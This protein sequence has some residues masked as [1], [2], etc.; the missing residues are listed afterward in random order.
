MRKLIMQAFAA[1]LVAGTLTG[2]AAA[3]G[4]SA[5]TPPEPVTTA[6]LVQNGPTQQRWL[7]V[8]DSRIVLNPFNVDQGGSEV[9]QNS[10]PELPLNTGYY[11]ADTAPTV[12][13][14][15]QVYRKSPH[16]DDHPSAVGFSD[17]FDNL[18]PAWAADGVS[19]TAASGQATL[20]VTNSR[21]Y[22]SISR[23]VSV[24]LSA[25]PKVTITVP[26]GTA[27]WA[28]KVNDGASADV[29]LQHDSSSTGSFTYDVAALSGWSG[30]K[31]LKVLIFA[32]G[33]V[34]AAVSIDSIQFQGAAGAGEIVSFSDDFD[35][36]SAWKADP[37]L[38]V[39]AAGGVASVA[40]QGRGYASMTRSVT[41]D[42]TST[43]LLTVTVP[44]TTGK[45][46][47]KVTPEGGTPDDDK[48]LQADT[49]AVGTLSYDLGAAT[50]WKGSTTFTIR[51][52][53]IGDGTT[54]TLDRLFI[55]SG[56]L[57]VESAATSSTSW[58]PDRLGFTANYSQ[59]SVTGSDLFHDADSVTRVITATG[60]SGDGG[61]LLLAGAVA[62]ASAYD[63][64]SRVLT[65]TGSGYTYAIAIPQE[66]V[67][68]FYS[69]RGA[70]LTGTGAS[71]TPGGPGSVWAASVPGDGTYAVGV[72]FA[73]GTTAADRDAAAARAT[74]ASSVS[75]A[76]SDLEKWASY[77]ND[78]FTAVPRAS[79]YSIRTV[80]STGVTAEQVELQYYRAWWNLQ[81]NVLP[82]TPETGEND[83]MLATGKASLWLYGS[84]GSRPVASWDSLLGM[85]YLV[86]IDP[87]NSWASFEGVM[88][89]VGADGSLAGESLPSRKA[90]TAWV[91]YQ[92]TGDKDKLAGTYDA[93]ARHLDWAYA[94]PRWIL[95]SYDHP[96]ERDAE[97]VA[98]LL[99]DFDYAKK[100]SALL[101]KTADVEH[102]NSQQAQMLSDYEKWFF[103]APGVTL[104]K[105]YLNGSQ[106]DD[107]GEGLGMYV[108]TGLHVSGLST[109]TLNALRDRFASDYNVGKQFAGLAPK[110]IKAPDAM[111]ILYGLLDQGMAAQ[112][113]G[114]NNSMI[115]D[116]VGSGWF[117]EV[118]QQSS[119]TLSGTPIASGVRPSLF[120][121]TNLI[122]S[123]LV[124]NGY[125][126]DIGEPSFVRLNTST[127]GV[128][129]LR[130]LGKALDVSTDASGVTHLSG[131]A[132]A[133]TASCRTLTVPV[134]STVTLSP[135]CRA[136]API[137][138]TPT[139][140]LSSTSVHP[141]DGMTVSGV[142]FEPGAAVTV[143]L[144]D[145]AVQ[146]AA[147][148][149][150][151]DGSFGVTVTI[152]K[153]TAVG[154]HRI[155]VR[156]GETALAS[157]ALSVVV[158]QSG[159]GPSGPGAGT[160]TP[161][162]SASVGAGSLAATGSSGTLALAVALALIA[163]GMI[164]VLGRRKRAAAQSTAEEPR[165]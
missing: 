123:V 125:R 118:Y 117:A 144:D 60:L 148:T 94:N 108:D 83:P 138:A 130:A 135:Q 92:A 112:A 67:V 129:G 20:A 111:F 30:K 114:F 74:A 46:A 121:I 8:P 159:S 6:D 53:Q 72:G 78:V 119:D 79:D 18:D 32:V 106:P 81:A 86:Q 36:V 19:A 161:G 41:V 9:S 84:P 85:Q 91:L 5:S 29:E 42:V 120:G 63:P 39:T 4:A 124:N 143:I 153:E 149:V 155:V 152:P 97:F 146:L 104:Y 132:I 34:G 65:V 76:Q 48:T 96:D 131:S 11:V 35:S 49:S 58:Q 17:S 31:D 134:G 73:P 1:M 98:S 64:S 68:E 82:A 56:A 122:D 80:D 28:L 105:H 25:T 52:Y 3:T 89:H 156:N 26:A 55:H 142:G 69:S 90:Q 47:L 59:G 23:T 139:L 50:G 128:T 2:T 136:G 51:M 147:L 95:G 87:E 37:G 141:G 61:S 44:S 16:D 115:R 162:G 12:K 101:G 133:D 40:L 7:S 99:I 21:G 77:W 110:A 14:L 13:D 33:Q 62:G 158:D 103:P 126:T 160:G 27:S 43:P 22:G 113:D 75:G 15:L 154:S 57:P 45:W 100:I 10:G 137:P 140:S 88:K 71:V 151:E 165:V 93:L 54:T 127:G 102:W 164:V 157:A 107:P 66:A 145:T 116:I 70:M 109:P 150:G 38:S 163:T 24:D